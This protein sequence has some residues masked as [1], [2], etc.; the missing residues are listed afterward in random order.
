MIRALSNRSFWL[1][2]VV[3]VVVGNEEPITIGVRI[4]IAHKIY[5]S[6]HQKLPRMYSS[7][8]ICYGTL[9]RIFG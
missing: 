5:F 8:D 6:I 2:V 4:R 1:V 9:R 7:P 3:V